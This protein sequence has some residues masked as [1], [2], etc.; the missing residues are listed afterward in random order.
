MLENLNWTLNVV[1]KLSHSPEDTVIIKKFLFILMDFD[2]LSLSA[3]FEL[4][5]NMKLINP[6]ISPAIHLE[7]ECKI[8]LSF[9]AFYET[10]EK[11]QL[12]DEN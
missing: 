2:G 7:A 9:F 3:T 10:L 6:G 5:Y 4:N 1:I 8:Q 12:I 11:L